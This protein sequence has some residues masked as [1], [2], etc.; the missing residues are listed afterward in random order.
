MR[1]C[2]VRS[3]S[4]NPT[5]SQEAIVDALLA[6]VHL[7]AALSLEPLLDLVGIL[8]RDLQADFVPFFA[9]VMGRLSELVETE[10]ALS[11]TLHS[12]LR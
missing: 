5:I 9:P 4:E 10:G 3:L 8:A 1:C 11:Q 6:R 2:G 12:A 7:R